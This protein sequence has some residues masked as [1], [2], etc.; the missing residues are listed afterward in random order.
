MAKSIGKHLF[1]GVALALMCAQA[2]GGPPPTPTKPDVPYGA[3]PH[4]SMDIFVPPDGTGPFPAIL[5][6][7]GIWKSSKGVPDLHRF[8]PAHCAV[9][10]V[11]TRGMDDA[12]R[13]KISP[14][15]SVVLLDAR[16]A[17]QFVRLHA[18]EWNLDPRRIAVAGGSQAGIPA[19]YVACEGEQANSQSSD[20][21]ERVSTKVV[22]AGSYRGPGSIDPKRLLEWDPGDAW[23]APSLGCS[24]ADSLKDRERLLPL[25]DLWSPDA[26]LTR[27]APPIYIEYDWGLTKPADIT[28]DNYRI[29]S[30]LLA[31]GFQKLARERGATCY[32]RFPGH[33]SEK[34]KSVWDFLLQQLNPEPAHP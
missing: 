1:P 21:V 26:L 34:Y 25:I 13:E 24:F 18:A 12:A 30:P 28:D 7:G 33:D 32:V 14:P 27:D 3:E 6:Y 10:G 22:C 19:L 23:G 20:P 11:E 5:F 4:Q 31:L 17:L 8:F 29:H 9:I 2:L 16:R 15:I